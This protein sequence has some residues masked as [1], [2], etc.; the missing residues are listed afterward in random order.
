VIPKIIHQV[1][2]G[3]ELPPH[4][5][6]LHK[7]MKEMNPDWMVKLW[8]EESVEILLCDCYEYAHSTK[9][10]SSNIIR[11]KALQKYGGVYF[12]LDFVAVKPIDELA[13]YSAFAARQPDGVICNAAMGAEPSHSWINAM[14]ENYGDQRKK[15][16]AWGCYIMEEHLT[17][18]V[19][20][21]PTDTFYPYGHHESKKP[22]TENTLAYHIWEGSWL[23]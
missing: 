15:D 22:P 6:D 2:I 21:L 5:A 11:L 17:P 20:L 18:D 10:G 3:G 4:L 7:A 8:D 16:A 14:L 23:K 13:K 1:W 9:A 12:D 19:T